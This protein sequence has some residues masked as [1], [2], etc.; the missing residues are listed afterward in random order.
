VIGIQNILALLDFSEASI[1][2]VCLAASLAQDHNARLYVLQVKEPFPVHGRIMAGSLEEVQ[3]HHRHKEKDQLSKVIPA[4]LKNSIAVEEIQ[5]IGMPVDRVIIETARKL[6]VD[7]IVIASQ[8]RKGLTRFLKKDLAQ[9]LL[10]NAPCS[11]FAVRSPL[12]SDYAV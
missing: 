11:V 4:R 9:Q 10:Q 2:A 12:S 8:R 3:K 5:V 6:G 7:L 1:N